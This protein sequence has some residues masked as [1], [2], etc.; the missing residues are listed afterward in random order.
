MN[1]EQKHTL[2]K[3]SVITAVYNGARFIEGALTSVL[4]QR[5]VEAGCYVI[6]GGSTDGT[7]DIIQRY[8]GRLA[9]WLS[10]PDQGISDAFNKGVE[11]TQGD[12]LM[13]LN[14]DDALAHPRA[15]ADLVHHAV[16][17]GLPDVIYGDCDLYDPESDAF[18]YRAIINYNRER[19]LHCETLPHPGMLMHRRYFNRFGK[20]DLS[21]KVAMDY[22]LFLRGVPSIGAFRAPLLVSRVRTGGISA[23]SRTLVIEETIR[24]L[25]MHGHL[26]GAGEVRMRAAYAARGAARRA[27]EGA[28]LYH[29]FDALRRRAANGG[30]EQT[31]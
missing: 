21:F 23:R 28:G 29:L 13:F 17:L 31:S 12:Y 11:R 8:A 19:F 2:P 9:G 5:D 10:E 18:L 26:N 6:D 3:I 22:E 14:A 1:V 15:L 7:V 20:F 27:L 25:K 24:A 30:K 16:E 4:K